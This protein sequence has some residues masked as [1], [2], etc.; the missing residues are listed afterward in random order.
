M[1]EH[2]EVGFTAI[3]V[4]PST[5]EVVLRL[6]KQHGVAICKLVDEAV[7]E[8]ESNRAYADLTQTRAASDPIGGDGV[9]R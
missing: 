1:E 2:T 5:K 3:M 7:R 9:H 8:Y 6:A 4:W